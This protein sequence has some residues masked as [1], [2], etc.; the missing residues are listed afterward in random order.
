MPLVGRLI[1]S[2]PLTATRCEDVAEETDVRRGAA[3]PA[4]I[5]LRGAA[6][7]SGGELCGLSLEKLRDR[8]V[9]C[10][11]FS[12]ERQDVS[13]R[14]VDHRK[15][16]T[17]LGNFAIRPPMRCPPGA[18]LARPM[19]RLVALAALT[20]LGSKAPGK[21]VAVNRLARRN[22]E[23]LQE[24]QAGISL[25][26]CAHARRHRGGPCADANGPR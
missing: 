7:R 12:V 22:Y 4:A 24:Y 19:P 8:R 25:Q 16:V 5:A 6:R 2:P 9:V 1:V 10:G 18:G 3:E 11:V 20:M 14:R 26:A 13:P 15:S 23:I 17:S 21:S